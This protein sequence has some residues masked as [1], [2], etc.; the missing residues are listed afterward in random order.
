M[1]YFILFR[2]YNI[3]VPWCSVVEYIIYYIYVM[4]LSKVVA[5]DTLLGNGVGG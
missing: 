4:V 5:E 1:G 2:C 3:S